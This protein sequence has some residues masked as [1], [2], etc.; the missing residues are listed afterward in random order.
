MSISR[1]SVWR[2]C[3]F[4]SVSTLL[5]A[6]CDQVQILE[7]KGSSPPVAQTPTPVPAPSN[8][9]DE[10]GTPTSEPTDGMEGDPIVPTPLPTE[11]E[12]P[13]PVDTSTPEPTPSVPPEETLTPTPTPTV[14]PAFF[15]YP[16]GDLEENSGQGVVD[17][18]I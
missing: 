10:A 11:T 4:L 14:E 13:E 2:L 17:D 7:P 12:T 15:Y 6:A 18:T 3:A 1:S 16:P 9:P 8:T 5:L